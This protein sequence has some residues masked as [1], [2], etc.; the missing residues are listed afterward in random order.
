MILFPKPLCE[1]GAGSLSEL[2]SRAIEVQIMHIMSKDLHSRAWGLTGGI[3]SGK[4]YAA[5]IL[6]GLGIPVLDMDVMARRLM[7]AGSPVF[8]Q[9]VRRFGPLI[10]GQDGQIDRKALAALVFTSQERRLELEGIIHPVVIRQAFEMVDSAPLS[11]APTIFIESAL[12]FA[13][14][15]ER[16]L[17]RTVLVRA[18]QDVRIMRVMIRDK[19]SEQE[20]RARISAQMDEDAM[21]NRADIVWDNPDGSTGL[22][23]QIILTLASQEAERY[24][25]T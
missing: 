6:R 15:L 9:V 14:G 25:D 8:D 3:G 16:A 23:R 5:A 24:R 12:I 2:T 1:Q 21:Q 17:A 13:V 19:I 7:L 18:P 11:K 4:S 20:V 10:V 22:R